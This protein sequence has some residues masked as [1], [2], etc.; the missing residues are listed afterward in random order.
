MSS[1]AWSNDGVVKRQSAKQACMQDMHMYTDYPDDLHQ[2]CKEW[3]HRIS[4][5]EHDILT[6]ILKEV[7]KED[8]GSVSFPRAVVGHGVTVTL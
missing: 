4:Y 8:H 2:S 5:S 7:L 1:K 3:P 6:A